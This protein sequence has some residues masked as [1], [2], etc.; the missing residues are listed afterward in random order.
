MKWHPRLS[1]LGRVALIAPLPCI[2]QGLPSLQGYT[3][4]LNT[5]NAL[6]APEGTVDLLWSN[7][8]DA[9]FR[10]GAQ[11]ANN[12]IFTLG[13]FPYLEGAGRLSVVHNPTS[14][15]SIDD[16]SAN[17][18][19]QIP[20]LPDWMPKMA[21][22]A[23]DVAG[24]GSSTYFKTRYGVISQDFGA[25]RL[26]VGDG[27]GPD[28]MKG[29]FGGGE[30]TVTRWLQLVGEYDTTDRNVGTKL[31]TPPGLLPAGMTF[32]LTT[33]YA[34]GDQPRRVNLAFSLR[35]PLLHQSSSVPSSPAPAPTSMPPVAESGPASAL[36]APP[37]VPEP[38]PAPAPAPLVLDIPVK[39]QDKAP[40]QSSRLADLTR[41]LTALGFENVRTGA[42]GK[43]LV[44][45]YE[46][47]R[48]N[49][50]EV[51]GLGLV[52]G[53]TV[54][55]APAEFDTFLVST[56]RQ[57]LRMLEVEGPIQP[58]LSFFRD[59]NGRDD[60]MAASLTIRR[61]E[62]FGSLEGVSWS[63]EVVNQGWLHSR[64]L[65]GPGL[66]TSIGTEVGAFNYR[67]SLI[68]DLQT[69]LWRGALLNYRWD[70]P[71]A[72]S[73]TYGPGG[74]FDTK[75]TTYN[76]DRIWV[77]Q[78]IPLAP[79]LA[80]QVGGGRYDVGTNGAMGDLMWTSATGQN[81]L[82]LK[83]AQFRVTDQPDL[84]V[85]LGA[86]RYYF[87]PLETYM[88]GTAGRF[89]N[90]DKG[91]R[92]DMKRYF[93]DVSFSLWYSNTD[94]H[95]AGFSLAIPLT[96]RRDMTPGWLQVRGT[97]HF[98]DS[99]GVRV[100]NGSNP[101]YLSPNS[102]NIPDTTYNLERSFYNN[103]RLNELYIQAHLAR[104]WEAYHLYK[105]VLK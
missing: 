27:T 78:V 100:Q 63:G 55:A 76:L 38:G 28:R 52:L 29:L 30:W 59:G 33:K 86:Y 51:D 77:A 34:L 35:V 37:Q 43:T 85:A 72:W 66:D 58:F 32:G 105:S 84:R 1:R 93:R 6:V 9:R 44:V 73:R 16:L 36:T 99:L 41:E 3:G 75:G 14:Q 71:V 25:L 4:L 80:A 70:I 7:Q 67:L 102:G 53:T 79:G 61:A 40:V 10:N 21:L 2:A 96:P 46:N 95:K 57:N 17:F 94:V 54:A 104:L 87:A 23:Q 91:Y 82:T 98:E 62:S 42:R 83:A 101:G 65:L 45:E 69:S 74:A 39:P 50:N 81:R 19:V 89:Y 103:D 49:H 13:M 24:T 22:G 60:Q 90:N 56:R 47:N 5:P 48:F 97:E 11:L 15:G 92:I 64:L 18:K 68:P 31:L 8:A 88:E 12:D 26:S 20:F